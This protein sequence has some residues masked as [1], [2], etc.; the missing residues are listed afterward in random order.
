MTPPPTGPFAGP[1][2]GE[3]VPEP[4]PPPPRSRWFNKVLAVIFIIFCM[5]LGMFLL[6]FPWSDLWDRNFFSS[7]SPVWRHFWGNAYWRGM[8]SGLGVVNVYIS[9]MEIFRLRRFARR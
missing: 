8:I 6:I 2:A 1:F 7:L 3:V 4:L 9:L 5:E